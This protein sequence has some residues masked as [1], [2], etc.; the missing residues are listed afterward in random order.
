MAVVV[1][2]GEPGRSPAS[3]APEAETETRARGEALLTVLRAQERGTGNPR[4]WLYE[5]LIGLTTADEATKVEMFRF[6]DAL[7]ALKTPDAIARHLR[8]YLLE[9]PDLKLPPGA[10]ALLASLDRTSITRRLLAGASQWGGRAMAR[11]FIAGANAR[12]ATGA[13]ERLRRQNLAFTLDLLGEAV[14]SEAEALAYQ[15]QYLDLIR[16]LSDTAAR[17]ARQ[18]ADR[19]G[20]VRAGPEGQRFREAIVAVRPLRPDGRRRHGR[21]GQGAPAPDPV[22]GPRARRV[23]QLR[24]GAARLL[25]PDAAHLLRDLVRGR[26]P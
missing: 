6:V 8:E 24:H 18:P 9:R 14:T 17:L 10:R 1:E 13:V 20:A 4:D 7:P 26:V 3:P 25:R 5:I 16:D 11:R 19:P 21:G 2:Q 12:E 22:A 23:R 15:K